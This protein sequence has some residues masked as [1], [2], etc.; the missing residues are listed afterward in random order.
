MKKCERTISVPESYDTINFEDLFNH[1][2]IQIDFDREK[3]INE[4]SMI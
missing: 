2:F 4:K 1:G 3:Q